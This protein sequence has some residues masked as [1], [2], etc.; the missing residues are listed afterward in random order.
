MFLNQVN[1]TPLFLYLNWVLTKLGT[2]DKIVSMKAKKNKRFYSVAEVAEILDVSHSS[3]L[4][5]L[6]A[7]KMDYIQR[8]KG[9]VIRIPY[10]EVPTEKRIKNLNKGGKNDK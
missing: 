5:L 3:V 7:G 8:M 9:A 2:G 10:Y 4:R 6:Q 1:K